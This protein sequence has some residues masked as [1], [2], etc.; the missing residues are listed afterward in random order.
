[1]SYLVLNILLSGSLKTI[2]CVTV[3]APH[4]FWKTARLWWHG[5]QIYFDERTATETVWVMWFMNWQFMCCGEYK[6][7]QY[8]KKW[9]SYISHNYSECSNIPWN[10]KQP[11]RFAVLTAMNTKIKVFWDDTT[12][13]SRLLPTFRR[14]LRLR[15]RALPTAME[16]W[17]AISLKVSVKI[18]HTTWL[19]ISE[20]SHLFFKIWQGKKILLSLSSW[21]Q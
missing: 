6:S 4:S 1:M 5:Q 9:E 7:L 11:V 10:I 14:N 2:V 8:S 21:G 13:R 16:M 18:Y 20:S 3:T 12:W 19:Q 15:L 17:A